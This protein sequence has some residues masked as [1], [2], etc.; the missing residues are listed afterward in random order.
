MV[1][2]TVEESCAVKYCAALRHC[3]VDPQSRPN[4]MRAPRW[5]S[6]RS[7]RVPTARSAAAALATDPGLH[8]VHR[9]RDDLALVP[10]VGRALAL[11]GL[12]GLPVAGLV[13][14]VRQL[15]RVR[16]LVV[17]GVALGLAAQGLLGR[18]ALHHSVG[19]LVAALLAAKEILLLAHDFFSSWGP[20]GCTSA[21]SGWLCLAVPGSASLR[22]ASATACAGSTFE[23]MTCS[24]LFQP[25]TTSASPLSMA[26][27]PTRATIAG[28]SFFMSLPTLVSSRSARSKN[29]V[30]VGPAI[31]RLTVTPVCFL[32]LRKACANDSPR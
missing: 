1:A 7:A 4:V 31:R 21:Y 16:R 28:S 24:L 8:D 30:S 20:M 10:A 9:A 12:R 27:K 3:G 17:R 19:M 11:V 22:C 32:S 29:S 5:T 18:A 15:G 23:L 2:M 13:V 25:A 14:V 26:S 6:A